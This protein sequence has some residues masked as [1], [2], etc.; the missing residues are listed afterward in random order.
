[1]TRDL[2]GDGDEHE[3]FSQDPTLVFF[4]IFILVF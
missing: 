2:E 3:T 1:M 4:E